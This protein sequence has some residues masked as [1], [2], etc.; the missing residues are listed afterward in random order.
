MAQEF[1]ADPKYF[2]FLLKEFEVGK[3]IFLVE[4]VFLVGH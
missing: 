1:E 4:L 3:H 2:F